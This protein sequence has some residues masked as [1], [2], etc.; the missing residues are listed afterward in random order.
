MKNFY[1]NAGRKFEQKLAWEVDSKVNPGSGNRIDAPGDIPT[2]KFLI[3]SKLTGQDHYVFSLDDWFEHELSAMKTGKFPVFVLG[4]YGGKEYAVMH[5]SIWQML[6]DLPEHY[7]LTTLKR[8]G[9][10]CTRLQRNVLSKN[11]FRISGTKKINIIEF[12]IDEEVFIIV[13]K[14]LFYA[15]KD[16]FE[17]Q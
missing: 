9:K 13:P 10:I 11:I 14:Q 2:A 12:N 5:T 17:C 8:K 16:E 4:F 7:E 6:I 3:E 1:Q 15:L